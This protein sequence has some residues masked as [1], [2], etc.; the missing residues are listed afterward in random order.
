[1]NESWHDGMYVHVVQWYTD[2]TRRPGSDGRGLQADGA[3][4]A[5]SSRGTIARGRSLAAIGYAD[6]QKPS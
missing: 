4:Y 3:V 6:D 2:C 5:K 1:M